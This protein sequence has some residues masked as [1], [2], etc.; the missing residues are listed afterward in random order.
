MATKTRTP[1]EVWTEGWPFI[2]GALVG[3]IAGWSAVVVFGGIVLVAVL[4]AWV[5]KRKGW[6]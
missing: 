1:Q 4:L 3:A 2:G 5:V 6:A